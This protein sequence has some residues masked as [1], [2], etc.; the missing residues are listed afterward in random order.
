M[1]PSERSL[2]NIQARFIAVFVIIGIVMLVLILRL[3]SLQV[4]RHDYF[5]TLSEQNRL[6]DVY[7]PAPRGKISDRNGVL[8]AS[9]RPSF[10]IEFVV[11]DSPTPAETIA[12]LASIVGVDRELLLT[13]SKQLGKRRRCLLYT[14]PSPRD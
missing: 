1:P 12:R 8:L 11:E 5:M 4:V 6:R 13:R 7:V 14:S 9:N 3:W 10:N 2:S